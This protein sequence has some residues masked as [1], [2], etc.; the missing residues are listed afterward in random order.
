MW[1]SLL[2]LLSLGFCVSLRIWAA[3]GEYDK[4]S[5]SAWPSTVV[6]LGQT[7]TLQCHSCSPF[8]LFRLFKTDGTSLPELQGHHVKTFTLGPV[9][10]EHAGSYTCSGAY[11]SRHSDPLQIVV[12]GVFTKPAI[13]AHPGPL[14]REERNVT[15]RCH[16]QLL[17]DKYILH[18]ENSTGHFQR[19][20]ETL[21]GGHAA[22]DFFIGPMTSGSAGTYR[23]Y[24]SLSRSP[25]EWSAPSDPVD[26]VI[27]GLSKKP[28]LTARG[29]PVVRSGENV[30]LLCSSESA[31]DQFHLLRDGENLGRPLAGGRGPRGA[32][33]AAFPLGPG[34]PAHSGAHRCYGSLTRSP[35]LWSDPSDPLLLCVTGSTKS[36]CPSTMDPHT[37]EEGK[38]PQGQSSQLH[39]LLRLSVAFIYTSIFLAVL[40]C[41]WLTKKSRA[42]WPTLLSLLSLGFWVSLR[43]WAAVG[44]YDKPSLS[45]WPSTVVPL[46]QTV[47][48][49]CHSRSPFAIFRLFKRD[50]TSL[51]ELQ[52]HHFNTFT[53]GPVAREHAGSYTCSGGYQSPHSDALQIVVTGVFTKPAISAHPG[54]LVQAGGNVTLRCH[55]P[56]LLDKFMLHK[57]GSNGHFQRRGETLLGG[58]APA[59]FSI[60]PMTLARAGSYRCYSSLSRSPY[61]W[62]APSGAV[63]I[64]ITGRFKKPS[65]SAQGGPVVRSGE[66]MTLICSSERDFDQFHLLREGKNFGRL[67]ARGRGPRGALQ[68][69]FPLGPGTPAHSGAYRC[70][71]SFTHSPYTWSDPSDPLL[72][73]VT[74]STTSTCPSPMDP[75]T[76][77]EAGLPQER[78]SVLYIILVLAIAFTST[79]ILLAALVCHWCSTPNHLAIMDGEPQEDEAVSGDVSP[80]SPNPC[81]SISPSNAQCHSLRRS[82]LSPSFTSPSSQDSP[83]E[84]VI[85]AHLNLGT[86]SERLNT[87]TPLRP[88]HP[89]PEPSIYEEFNVKKDHAEL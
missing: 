1:P 52:G 17:F 20:G 86:I 15:L 53:L 43:I 16:S 9:T 25:Y 45:A 23:C 82:R 38:L 36:T 69:V 60:G 14:V 51:P 34:T 79:I 10:R 13:S 75:H 40:V 48:L 61:E 26:I 57:K 78:S 27:T 35:Y 77:E 29:G 62:L 3:V 85:Y 50:G 58:H 44:E 72:L 89:F 68:A 37:T 7:V 30:T 6:P 39:L 70:F 47:T 87:H 81:H 76:T 4:P 31:F 41:H 63:D 18:Q 64:V 5:L 19:R 74:G 73:C 21:P 12:T 24:G 66:N 2:S 71:G 54:P 88:M 28:S 46:G 42:M 55:S 84:D 56:L 67:L 22:A 80:P 83:A 32:L 59:H 8:A 49:P 33:Q 65:L 11:Q